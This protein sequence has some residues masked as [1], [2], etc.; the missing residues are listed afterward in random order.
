MEI[1][2]EHEDVEHTLY[3]VPFKN[4][5]AEAFVIREMTYTEEIEAARQARTRPSL[6]PEELQRTVYLEEVARSI[7]G[8]RR[9]GASEV[10]PVDQP[11]EEFHRWPAKLRRLAIEAFN[12]MNAMEAEDLAV[13]RAGAKPWSPAARA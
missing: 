6:T 10:T 3:P 9:P 12:L 1:E 11:F 7:V 5:F 13:F 4:R 8:V 2:R